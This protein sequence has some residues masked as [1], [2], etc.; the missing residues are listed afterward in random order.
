[1]KY[2]RGMKSEISK[3]E[4]LPQPLKS[5]LNE[6]GYD[7]GS[8]PTDISATRLKDSPRIGRLW[9]EHRDKIENKPL[10]RG[11]AKLGEAWHHYMFLHAPDHWLAEHRFYATVNGKIISGAIDAVEPVG[12]DDCIVWDY[13]LMTAYKAQT[14]LKDFERQLNIYAWLLRQNG[15]NPVSLRISACIRDWADAKWR[16]NNHDNSYP[17]SMFPVYEMPLW[18]AEEAESYVHERTKHHTQE[19]L[20][21]CS[22]EERWMSEPKFAVTSEKTKKALKL[23]DT[24]EGA[25]E[26][27]ARVGSP[28]YIEKR[29]AEPIRCQRFCEVAEF[30]SQYQAELVGKE[31]LNT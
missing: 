22:D 24:L 16:Y 9:R 14:E 1:M 5:F 28:T 4:G 19:E 11:F 8:L 23:F 21:L 30:C 13:K 7:A 3:K 31:L 10:S 26:H 29:T 18:S 15:K 12:G 6:D 20:P 25:T 2:T 27:A 17:H